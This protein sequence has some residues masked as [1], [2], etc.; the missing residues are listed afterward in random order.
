MNNPHLSLDSS[1]A[2]SYSLSVAADGVSIVFDHAL[3]EF[4]ATADGTPAVVWR[5][6]YDR[7]TGTK[8]G[9]VNQGSGT[10]P[11]IF[12]DGGRYVAITD[13][14]DDRMHVLVYRRDADVPAG[15]RL[16]AGVRSPRLRPR[17]VHD[18]QLPDQL[19]RQPGGREQLR[20]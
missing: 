9:S 20:L 8:P 17:C 11:D 15:W 2:R 1:T 16:A 4:T 19:G 5:Q 13:N 3:Y 12:G 10:T 14:A 7:G 6:T 18:G